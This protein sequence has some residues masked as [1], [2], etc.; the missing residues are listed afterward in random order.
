[1]CSSFHRPRKQSSDCFHSSIRCFWQIPAF[2]SRST[3]MAF[4]VS[5]FNGKLPK[6]SRLPGDIGSLHVDLSMPRRTRWVRGSRL[7]YSLDAKYCVI[8]H[9]YDRRDRRRLQACPTPRALPCIP[10][11]ILQCLVASA[12]GSSAHRGVAESTHGPYRCACRDRCGRTGRSI[13]IGP[14]IQRRCPTGHRLGHPIA[15]RMPR[16]ALCDPTPF[17]S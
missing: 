1:M 11:E 13:F 17:V 14:L 15:P 12:G 6:S 4:A 16:Q 2:R 8:S 7:R 9:R 5:R 10:Q 3:R